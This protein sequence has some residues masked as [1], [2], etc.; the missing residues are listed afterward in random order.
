[1]AGGVGSAA[2]AAFFAGICS[3]AVLV[4][5]WRPILKQG[6]K[7]G[8]QGSAKVREVCVKAMENVSDVAYEVRSELGLN[9]FEAE[10]PRESEAKSNGSDP[11]QN[12]KTSHRTKQS[13]LAD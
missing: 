10:P 11:A 6:V 9:G 8:I 1:V 7:S 2:K 3:G 13:S 5:K 4:T 12:G